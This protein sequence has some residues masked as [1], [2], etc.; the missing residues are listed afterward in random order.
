M[1]YR[2]KIGAKEKL[3]T[4]ND[5][6]IQKYKNY[7][8]KWKNL[9][10]NSNHI[11]LEIGCGRGK[12]ITTLAQ[13]NPHIN[14]IAIEKLDGILLDCAK[15]IEEKDIKNIKIIC[16]D[17]SELEEIF[18][19][20]ELQRIYINFCDPW[21]KKR[22]SKRRLTYKGFLEIYTNLMS[23]DGEIHFKTDNKD[24]FEF[25]INEC[26]D[27][28]LRLKNIYLDLHKNEEISRNVV[29]TEYEEKFKGMGMN[30][31]K[32]EAYSWNNNI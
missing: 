32:L 15:K 6:F 12:F 4:Y 30:I 11:H 5:I 28:G 29:T 25:S 13:N 27:F 20:K 1:R 18:D 8:G 3:T 9:F 19:H 7:K 2:K 14:Y 23:E 21:P 22:H 16:A 24:L 26:C 31:Y 10:Q 17:A